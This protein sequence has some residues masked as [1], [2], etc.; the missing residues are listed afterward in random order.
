VIHPTYELYSAHCALLPAF[1]LGYLNRSHGAPLRV[2]PAT[3]PATIVTISQTHSATAID[4][5]HGVGVLI[6]LMM[7][8]LNGPLVDVLR[9][10]GEFNH[11]YFGGHDGMM[12]D[13]ELL[14]RMLDVFDVK[15]PHC[16]PMRQEIAA[17]YPKLVYPEW[18]LTEDARSSLSGLLAHFV[19]LPPIEDGSTS[20]LIRFAGSLQDVVMGWPCINRNDFPSCSIVTGDLIEEARASLPEF[21]SYLLWEN[22]D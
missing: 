18:D 1:F 7:T 11:T 22:S 9:M 17:A 12:P 13:E 8:P 15:Y 5:A 21:A 19:D 6:P 2:D 3:L 14:E 4:T 20:A 16:R 10:F